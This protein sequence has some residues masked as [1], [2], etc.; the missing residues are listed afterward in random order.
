MAKFTQTKA[1]KKAIEN[2]SK[3][4]EKAKS[5]IQYRKKTLDYDFSHKLPIQNKKQIHD[6]PTREINKL[7]NEIH[8]NFNVKYADAFKTMDFPNVTVRTS[9]V[10]RIRK[11]EKDAQELKDQANK[12]LQNVPIML[13]QDG[14]IVPSGMT[15]A[16][17]QQYMMKPDE[18]IYGRMNKYNFEKASSLE[19]IEKALKQ[20]ERNAQPDYIEW[21]RTIM[22]DN[23][24]NSLIDIFNDEADDTVNLLQ[25]LDP[26]DFYILSKM[27]PELVNFAYFN[28]DQQDPS[29]DL[30]DRLND[31]KT[32]VDDYLNGDFELYA[33]EIF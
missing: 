29:E 14:Q 8:Q 23:F 17:Q 21:R 27:F 12:E 25:K 33:K 18:N 30:Y 31:L 5:K 20:R 28:S 3:E 19:N 4:W 1:R 16:D 7:A 2:F 24:I 15:A 9:I 32:V 22:K 10:K 26:K 6:L 13:F 11:A